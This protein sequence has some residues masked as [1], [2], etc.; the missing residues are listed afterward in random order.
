MW[1][2]GENL[3]TFYAFESSDHEPA[4][5]GHV[6]TCVGAGIAEADSF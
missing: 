3:G 1:A 6:Y 4:D 2:Q 5:L